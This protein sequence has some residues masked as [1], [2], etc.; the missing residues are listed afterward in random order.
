MLAMKL[1]ET[2]EDARW[3]MIN[4]FKIRG[5]FKIKINWM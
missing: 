4:I 2:G 1:K 3:F 5:I